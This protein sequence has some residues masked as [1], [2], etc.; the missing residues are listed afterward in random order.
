MEQYTFKEIR[1]KL[2][3]TQKEMAEKFG[4]SRA[5]YGLQENYQRPMRIE[6]FMDM[7]IEASIDPRDVILTK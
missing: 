5:Y 2:G 7:C 1:L 6:N 3:K 4:I